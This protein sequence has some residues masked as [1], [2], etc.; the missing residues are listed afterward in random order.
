MSEQ[1]VREEQLT[2]ANETDRF[3]TLALIREFRISS[4]L[5]QLRA[6]AALLETSEGPGAPYEWAKVNRLIGLLI[7][8][9]R[10]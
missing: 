9:Q 3:D 5:P 1:E 4:T 6:L 8:G 7:E 2:S 10:V